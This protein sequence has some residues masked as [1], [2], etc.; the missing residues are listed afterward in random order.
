MGTNQESALNRWSEP[1]R[2]PP[3]SFSRATSYFSK[4]KPKQPLEEKPIESDS[5]SDTSTASDSAS[6]TNS[7]AILSPKTV[8]DDNANTPTTD[9]TFG[10]PA[11]QLDDPLWPA[12]ELIET[13][14]GVFTTKSASQKVL[15]VKT[16]F[17]PFLQTTA[18][19]WST[20]RLYPENL[21]RRTQVL[22]SWWN[23]MLDMLDGTA[24]L[25]VDRPI[26]YEALTAIMMRLEWRL[27]TP[28]FLSY[29]DRNL[30][31]TLRCD[32]WGKGQPPSSDLDKPTTLIEAAEHN[33]R[34]TFISSLV[35]QVMFAVEK[36]S[37]RYAPLPLITF[38]GK[39]CA[40][41]FF[42]IPGF[43]E[44]LAGQWNISQHQLKRTA[45]EL[46]IPSASRSTEMQPFDLFPPELL[47]LSWTTPRS[48]FTMLRRKHPTPA[49]MPTLSWTGHWMPR[50]RG[51]DT[52]LFFVFCKYFH[53]LSNDFMP[54][55]LPMAEKAQS[56]AFVLVQA[57]L[58][59]SIDKTLHRRSDEVA[60]A[61]SLSPQRKGSVLMDPTSTADA[62]AMGLTLPASEF[63]MP[64]SMSESS[65]IVLLKGVLFDSS[66]EQEGARVTFAE[67]FSRLLAGAVRKTSLFDSH[68]CFTLCDFL[69][70]SMAHY[71]EF[72]RPKKLNQYNDWPF[73]LDIFKKMLLSLNTVTEVRVL[74]FI[75][76][77][78]NIITRDPERKA[79]LCI[80]WL[81]S[82]EVFHSFY[83]HW[84]PLVRSYYHRLLC[85]RIC[86]YDGD[87]SEL[88][89]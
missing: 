23:E 84:C 71:D 63:N 21:N 89:L 50:W 62:T 19:H 24:V 43:A 66:A 75:F 76:S 41:A 36:A 79:A 61:N 77:I 1:T 37:L 46:G 29:A 31:E 48:M 86:R 3:K 60:A 40:Y 20:K 4:T 73:W 51:L 22:S 54:L 69:E 56:P 5:R 67:T 14:F 81:L 72:A 44:I 57:Q 83:N 74:G 9:D 45:D 78:W 85:W 64:K 88:D 58:L 32:T 30:R 47:S 35:K 82:E 27:T 87:A 39:T 28:H 42:F 6:T 65:V 17:L 16:A 80:D 12:F 52:D 49:W 34:T 2:S 15:V 11:A 53:I 59:L 70:E 7:P 8:P 10:E 38:A 25:K 26:L 55:D 68:A 18:N 33:V 13:D